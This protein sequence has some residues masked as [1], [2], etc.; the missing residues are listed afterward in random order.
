MKEC[1]L[2]ASARARCGFTSNTIFS[3]FG[4]AVVFVFSRLLFLCVWDSV[5]WRIHVAM[6][7]VHRDWKTSI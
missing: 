7:S 3:F 4:F 1:E 2:W 6:G 5:T